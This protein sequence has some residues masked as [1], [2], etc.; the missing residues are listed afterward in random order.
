MNLESMEILEHY[1]GDK[2]IILDNAKHTETGETVIVY[3]AYPYEVSN[4]V[5]VRPTSMF[6]EEV[7]YN[8]ETVPRFKY[9]GHVF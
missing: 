9:Y 6:R 4:Q 7:N 3:T 8:G 5:W 2:Y 1:K